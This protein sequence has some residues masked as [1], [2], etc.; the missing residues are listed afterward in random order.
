VFTWDSLVGWNE[1]ILLWLEM[2]CGGNKNVD[3]R[4][5]SLLCLIPVFRRFDK[6][7][8]YL[9][10]NWR[11]C[12]VLG[13]ILSLYFSRKCTHTTLSYLSRASTVCWA[14]SPVLS[15]EKEIG[16]ILGNCSC[17]AGQICSI[18]VWEC[19]VTRWFPFMKVS[20]GIKLETCRKLFF[21]FLYARLIF[22][23]DLLVT[24]VWR[25]KRVT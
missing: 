25:G 6:I 14:F 11:D 23:P 7:I 18:T 2:D 8:A 22:P 19:R 24:K 5:W 21:H 1:N 13:G 10:S 12:I 17:M 20:H 9:S 3:R 16:S 4:T 15:G